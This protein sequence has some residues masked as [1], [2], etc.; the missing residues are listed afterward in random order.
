MP[1]P[2]KILPG[3][4][5]IFSLSVCLCSTQHLVYGILTID[6]LIKHMYNIYYM[7]GTSLD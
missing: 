6:I 4:T 3:I 1:S 2:I 5:I 7:P